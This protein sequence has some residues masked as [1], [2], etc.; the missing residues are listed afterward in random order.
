MDAIVCGPGDIPQ[1]HGADEYV[2]LDHLAQCEAMIER[3]IDC[4]LYT[5][6]CV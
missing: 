6:R 3:L 2:E 5:S 4:L 1:A